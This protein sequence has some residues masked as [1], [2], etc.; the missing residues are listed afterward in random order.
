M[1]HRRQALV[2]S[3]PALLAAAMLAFAFYPLP[4]AAGLSVS[5]HYGHHYGG[6]H[7][8]RHHHKSR[9]HGYGRHHYRHAP[10]H[11]AKRH[12]HYPYYS[13]HRY[14][15]YPYRYRSHG[16]S[17]RSSHY[18]Y[19]SQ[20]TRAQRASVAADDKHG[21]K[22]LAR[23]DARGAHGFF[24]RQAESNP[25]AGRPKAGYAL[26]AALSGDLSTGTWAMRRAFRIDPKALD[27]VVIGAR[28]RPKV[29]GLIAHYRDRDMARGG[30]EAFMIAALEYLLRDYKGARKAV[31]QAALAGDKS[32]STANLKRLLSSEPRE[33]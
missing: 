25:R 30:D 26:A 32:A 13:S 31:H 29:E 8:Y 16:Y 21:W 4:A 11:A 23:G 33:M 1:I 28:L 27:Y 17:A 5:L 7:K 9:R 12:R 18:P 24:A 10:K 2:A 6:H 15:H 3:L 20:S 22:L 14:R 19:R